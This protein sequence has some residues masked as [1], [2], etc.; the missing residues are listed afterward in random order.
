MP[1][2]E[3]SDPL[4]PK[5]QVASVPGGLLIVSVLGMGAIALSL[6]FTI[7]RSTCACGNPARSY[8]GAMNRAQQAYFLENNIFTAD[9][10]KLGLGIKTETENYRYSSR[11]TQNAAFHY[12]V[13]RNQQLQ[14]YVG[15]VFLVPT[16][17]FDGTADEISTVAI[18]CVG[19]SP[20]TRQPAEPTYQNG[21]LA[22]GEGTTDL[23]R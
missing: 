20:S 4:K 2:R 9:I 16:T 23:S 14:S 1:L 19:N 7:A 15:G 13:S 5:G 22:C 11:V 3:Q 17:Q 21:V 8:V 10:E 6:V 12:G 18:L